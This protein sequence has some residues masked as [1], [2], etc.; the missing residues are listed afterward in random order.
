METNMTSAIVTAKDTITPVAERHAPANQR[1]AKAR[2]GYDGA[3]IRIAARPLGRTTK[4]PLSAARKLDVRVDR[5]ARHKLRL[6]GK[7]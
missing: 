4:D 1:K 3:R 5:C 2:P 6:A 7:G